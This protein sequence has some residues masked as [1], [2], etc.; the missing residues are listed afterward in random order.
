M[1]YKYGPDVTKL[2]VLS[3]VEN[4]V[5]WYTYEELGKWFLDT[6]G[7]ILHAKFLGYAH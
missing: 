7:K 2:V 4:L 5:Y 6:L 1:Y 3:Y